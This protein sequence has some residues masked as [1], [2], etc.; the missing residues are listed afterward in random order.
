MTFRTSEVFNLLSQEGK[1]YANSH[2]KCLRL[3]GYQYGLV[4]SAKSIY[5]IGISCDNDFSIAEFYLIGP[6]LIAD[7]LT[8]DPKE[9]SGCKFSLVKIHQG[10]I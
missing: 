7:S 3:A 2:W 4:L 8:K 5:N 10:P 1:A 6:R 9:A